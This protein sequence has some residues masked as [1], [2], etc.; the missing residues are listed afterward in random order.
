MSDASCWLQI[1]QITKR[2][3]RFTALDA[4]DLTVQ[5]GEL[6]CLLGPSGCGKT[7]L[8]RV[9]AGLER[10]DRGTI[11]LGKRDISQLPPAKRGF[12]IVFQSYALFPHLTVAAN[13][14]YGLRTSTAEKNRRVDELLELVG[15]PD[16]GPKYPRQLSGGQQQRIALARALATEPA[17]LLLDEPLSAL[18]AA[19][20]ER[21]RGELRA[22][23]QRLSITTVMVTH[24]QEEALALAD[25][26]AVMNRG[27]IEQLDPPELL[28]H[29]PKTR[30]VASFVG[31]GSFVKSQ[32]QELFVRP[33][34]VQIGDDTEDTWS[35]DVERLEF[36]GGLRR[37]TLALADG[38]RLLAELSHHQPP[39]QPGQRVGVLLPTAA[40]SFAP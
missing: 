17:L 12:G 9:L 19:V 23:Q 39:L 40:A 22:L 20:R 7:T 38:Q 34:Q 29:Q 3:G 33:E 14:A 1:S 28:Y 2:F 16:S 4:V 15:L 6:L 27:R 26:I 25:R 32:N 37:V 10:Q 5:Q 8:L 13:V 11:R 31:R 36:L 30:F 21:L 18:D 24:D 35:A